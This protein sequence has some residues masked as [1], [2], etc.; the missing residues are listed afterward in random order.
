MKLSTQS[1]E[2][3]LLRS[4]PRQGE[5]TSPILNLTSQL[6]DFGLRVAVAN[7][8][9]EQLELA[10]ALLTTLFG[11]GLDSL[12]DAGGDGDGAVDNVGDAD[13]VVLVEA[14]GGHGRGAH[15]E[16]A[17]DEGGAVAGNGVLVGGYADELEDTLDTAAVNAVGFEVREDKVVVC[18][19]ADEAISEAALALV[20]AEALG[21]GLGVGEDLGLVGME[22]GPL[23]L[24]E[25]DG[26]CR[27]GVVVRTALVAWEDGGVDGAFE[28]VHLVNFGLGVCATD[29]LAEEDEGSSRA[30]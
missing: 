11:G 5:G 24:L 26:E 17:G 25:G 6:D 15:S 27:D 1:T 28:V 30:S 20:L 13:K 10:R 19:A 14:A 3:S 22:V 8:V 29:A 21:E 16:A 23:G 9:E 4:I 7:V 18:A 2:A 12:V